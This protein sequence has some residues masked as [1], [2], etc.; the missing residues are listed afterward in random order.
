MFYF[1][2]RWERIHGL[3]KSEPVDG[4]LAIKPTEQVQDDGS[5]YKVP[6]T[7]IV[8]VFPHPNAERLE[9]ATVYGFQMIVQKD[10]YKAGDRVIYI[11]IDSIIPEW[12]EDILFPEGSKITLNK[13]RVRQIRIRKCASQGMIIDPKDVESHINTEYVALEENLATVLGITKYQPPAQRFQGFSGPKLRNKPFENPRFHKYGGIDNIKWYPNFFNEK[14]VIIQEKLHGSNCRASYAKSSANTLWK[15]IK[16]LFGFLPEYEYCYGSNNV[17][18][19]ERT[20]HSSLYYGEDVYGAVLKKVDAFSKLKPGETI[21]GELIG[22]GIQ[23]NY[24]YG[25]EERHFV[26]F[27]VKIERPDGSQEYLDPEE[28]E[29]FA[30]ERGFDFVPVLYRGVFNAEFAKKLATGASVYNNKQKVIEGVV[31]K[32]RK[33]Y[34]NNSSK[35]ALKLINEVY[36][37]DSSNTDFH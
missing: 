21:Y 1:K 11:P 16:K 18:L 20:N 14:E 32:V 29:A 31:I 4:V 19:Q 7:T 25:H 15:K 28:A 26:L 3:A 13:R 23:K 17:Q 36:L 22:E 27:D 8:A 2:P 37:D 6:F 34:G 10:K 5:I 24:D 35:K 9:L 33:E 30:K 12:L